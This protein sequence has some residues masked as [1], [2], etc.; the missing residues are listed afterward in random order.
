M[1]RDV[2]RSLASF[3]AIYTDYLIKALIKQ[4]PSAFLQAVHKHDNY[5]GYT[6]LT[7]QNLP[8]FLLTFMIS[9]VNTI[10]KSM[11]IYKWLTEK[12]LNIPGVVQGH[13]IIAI[14][15]SI[16]NSINITH[17]KEAHTSLKNEKI[18]NII[19]TLV[20]NKGFPVAQ[21]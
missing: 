15:G 13:K 20:A 11:N 6:N 8:V 9:L 17:Q 21:C 14:V 5:S 12:L 10:L 18:A 16:P 19:H 2:N 1:A 4:T 3:R 7:S